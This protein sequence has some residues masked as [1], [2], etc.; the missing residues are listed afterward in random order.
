MPKPRTPT[1]ILELKGAFKH[2]PA[3][4]RARANEPKLPGGVGEPPDWLDHEAR[5]EWWRVVPDL[6]TAGVTSRVEA[7]ALGA[8]CLAVS[9]LRKAQ[10]EVFRD[11]LT[12]MTEGGLRKHPAISI[13]ERAEATIKAFAAEFGMTPASRSKVQAKPADK[14]EPSS[15]FAAV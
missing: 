5:E 11:G 14:D 3:R 7:T 6:D 9:R 12:I 13:I 4:G 8:Y 10:A 2:D 15:S 1:K